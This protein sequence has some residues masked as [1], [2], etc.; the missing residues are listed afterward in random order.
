MYPEVMNRTFPFMRSFQDLV[1]NYLKVPTAR[2]KVHR[3]WA[4]LLHQAR[5]TISVTAMMK[6][7]AEICGVSMTTGRREKSISISG[8]WIWKMGQTT[9]MIPMEILRETPL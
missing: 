4:Y 9:H 6:M 1:K 3:V 2:Q 7:A 8:I 5:R